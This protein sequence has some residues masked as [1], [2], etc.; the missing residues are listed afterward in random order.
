VN[1]TLSAGST[2][3]SF[4]AAMITPALLILASGSLIATAL[5]RLSRIVDR[6]RNIAE[7]DA[8]HLI[9]LAELELERRRAGLATAQSPYSSSRWRFSF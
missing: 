9:P 2:A 4:I 8:S 5:A 3:Q 6:I 1:T 7:S